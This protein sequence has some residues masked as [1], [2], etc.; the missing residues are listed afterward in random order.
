MRIKDDERWYWYLAD[1]TLRLQTE[2][3]KAK[4]GEKYL[5]KDGTRIP[6]IPANHVTTVVLEGVWKAKLKTRVTRK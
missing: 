2:Y 5:L 1:R 3:T 4:D 6:Y